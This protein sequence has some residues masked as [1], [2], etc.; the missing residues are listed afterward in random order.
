MKKKIFITGGTGFIGRNLKEQLQ[1][2]YKIY[3]PSHEEL[4]LLN[5]RK[6]SNYLKKHHFDAIVHCAWNA[7]RNS[8]KD[9]N[10]ILEYNLRMFF[11]LAR[12]HGEYGKMI[13]YGSGAVYGREHWIHRMNEDYFDICVPKDQDVFSKYIM[14]KYA[15]KSENIY[16]LRVFG[17]FGKY[18]DWKIRF[19]SNACCRTVWDLP[20][21][22]KQNVFLDYLYIDDLIRI[23]GWFIENEPEDKCYN[24]CRG[25]TFDLLTLARKVL[26]VSGKRLD[27][28]VS[29]G[30]LGREYSGDNSKLLSKI[31]DY[32]FC[33]MDDCIDELYHW[34]LEK[35]DSIDG[36]LFL[37]Q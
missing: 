1:D 28:K 20:I 13:Y 7:A 31:G 15:E 9:T 4:E 16:N 5:E 11:N 3:A 29:H 6:V 37:C 17:V 25:E 2:K 14:C 34:Y 19:I 12:C 23:T 18:E 22:I 32:S 21:T 35:K 10:K 24:V 36:K 27:I 30:D 8:K 33:N 26:K